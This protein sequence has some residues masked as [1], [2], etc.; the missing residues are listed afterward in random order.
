VF[1]AFSYLSDEGILY[2]YQAGKEEPNWAVDLNH[3]VKGRDKPLTRMIFQVIEDTLYLEANEH[4]VAFA[5]ATGQL[6]WH[7]D[8][9]KELNLPFYGGF[10]G[11]G[12]NLAVFT[13]L[14]DTLVVSFEKRVVAMDLKRKRCLWHLEPNTFPHCPFPAAH[15][16]RLFLSSGKNRKLF[17]MTT[18][19]KHAF[20]THKQ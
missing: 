14:G 9:A 5:P 20:E 2:A 19:D 11:G 15:N 8:L 10:F 13:K 17:T 1:Y 12:L 6:L 16:G 18:A 3:I 4:I 7:M